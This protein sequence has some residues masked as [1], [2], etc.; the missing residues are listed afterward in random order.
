MSLKQQINILVVITSSGIFKHMVINKYF[1]PLIV[2]M[3][4]EFNISSN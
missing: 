4:D 3:G 1:S 2:P